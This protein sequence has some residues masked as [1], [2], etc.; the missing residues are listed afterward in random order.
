MAKA[1]KKIFVVDD[2]VNTTEMLKIHLNKNFNLDVLTFSTGEEC[3]RN[4]HL[5]PQYIVLDYS[6]N[7]VDKNAANGIEI[8]QKIK[9][10][11]N[12]SYVIF[13]SGQDNIEIA[14]DTMKFGAYDYIVKNQSSFLRLENCLINI[15]KNLRLKYMARVY[16]FSTI[17]LTGVIVL[18]IIMAILLKKYAVASNDPSWF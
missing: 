2:D 1:L 8:L 18:I 9:E 13:L 14:V 3:I 15:H 6:L 16:K 17:F 7:M 4:L 12:G 10:Q 5:E 11:N